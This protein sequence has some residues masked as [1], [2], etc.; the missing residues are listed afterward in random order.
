ML[1]SRWIPDEKTELA[2]FTKGFLSGM[3]A[4]VAGGLFYVPAD[5]VAQRLQIQDIKGFTQNCRLYHGPWDVVK[6]V[7]RLDGMKGLYRGYGAYVT[8]YAPGSAVQW[9]SYEASKIWMFKVLSRLEQLKYIPDQIPGKE[10]YV[11]ALS[12]G[13]AGICAVASN[14]PLEI[15]RIRTQLLESNSK[16]DAQIIRGGY[17]SL[18]SSIYKEEGWSAFYRGLKIRL[19][20]TVPSAVVALSGYELIKQYSTL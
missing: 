12:A 11:N 7:Y 8:A 6:R 19:L 13:I 10:Q 15:L 3:S 16:K 1:I 5:I 17:F 4:E 9:G 20:V 14:N 18:A 2:R